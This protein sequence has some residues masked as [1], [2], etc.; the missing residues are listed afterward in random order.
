M[1]EIMSESASL[2]F[3]LTRL[4]SADPQW[5]DSI[6]SYKILPLQDRE[7]ALNIYRECRRDWKNMILRSALN[8]EASE[9][10]VLLSGKSISIGN[11]QTHQDFL[12]AYDKASAQADLAE[13]QLE[14]QVGFDQHYTVLGFKNV[15][16]I[17]NTLNGESLFFTTS[18]YIGKVE[19]QKQIVHWILKFKQSIP[20][21]FFL[22]EIGIVGSHL[23]LFQGNSVKENLAKKIFDSSPYREIYQSALSWPRN[24]GLFFLLKLLIG[25]FLTRWKSLAGSV[26][27]K[28]IWFYFYLFA[29]N[30][31]R[32]NLDLSFIEFLNSLNNSASWNN[33]AAL[34]HIELLNKDR[35]NYNLHAGFHLD[36][37]AIFQGHGEVVTT[38][39]KAYFFDQLQPEILYSLPKNSVIFTKDFN[40]LAHG[41]LICLEQDFSI[42]GN[43]DDEQYLKYKNHGEKIRVNFTDKKIVLY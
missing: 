7:N 20:M 41:F 10:G 33:Q 37:G 24:P 38:S 9:T 16:L 19:N 23:Y 8:S 36:S 35:E 11:I 27:W 4:L 42:I 12:E 43:L 40:V 29:L 26:N 13:M 6:P 3:E 2:K 31:A 21:D 5:K 25:S 22:L 14:E 17:Q 15:F 34:K 18:T 32:Q 28:F 39:E 1:I 30:R